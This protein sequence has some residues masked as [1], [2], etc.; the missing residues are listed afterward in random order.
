MEVEIF[1]PGKPIGKAR[2][3]FSRTGSFVRVYTPSETTKYEKLISSLYKEKCSKMFTGYVSV[4]IEAIFPVPASVPKKKIEDY[5]SG[6]ILPD[7]KPDLDNICKI[8]LDGL[9]RAAFSDDKAVVDLM[10]K[11]R[12]GEN[13]GVRVIISDFED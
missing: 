2:P 10:A 1:I 7:K 6:K 13:P 3:K 11:K 4:S 12:Y 5:L 9:N 8:V